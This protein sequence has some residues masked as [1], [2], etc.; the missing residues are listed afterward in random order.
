M[1][2]NKHRYLSSQYINIIKW[3]IHHT[4]CVSTYLKFF[5]AYANECKGNA[6]PNVCKPQ[7]HRENVMKLNE[8]MFSLLVNVTGK[9]FCLSCSVSVVGT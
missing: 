8:V 3:S 6:F 2:Q 7:I 9:H 5:L 1:S 4:R